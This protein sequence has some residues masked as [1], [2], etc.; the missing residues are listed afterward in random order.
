ME[1][2][3]F[4]LQT[5]TKIEFPPQDPEQILQK[6]LKITCTIEE[7]TFKRVVMTCTSALL[8]VSTRCL[9]FIPEITCSK[10]TKD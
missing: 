2:R 1:R 4:M 8:L 10:K 7:N 6:S 5:K 9:K 3:R